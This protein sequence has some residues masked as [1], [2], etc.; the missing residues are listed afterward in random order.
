MWWNPKPDATLECLSTNDQLIQSNVLP[1]INETILTYFIKR[2]GTMFKWFSLTTL[3]QLQH[4][5]RLVV[6]SQ[7]FYLNYYWL[8]SGI[9]MLWCI[10]NNF[11]V[12]SMLWK[13]LWCYN[14][15]IAKGC[16]MA[17][18][19]WCCHRQRWFEYG[20]LTHH[21]R[22]VLLSHENYYFLHF[23]WVYYFILY[24]LTVRIVNDNW[25]S[26]RRYA[27]LIKKNQTFNRETMI[28]RI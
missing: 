25:L 6:N 16:P 27:I 19:S 18:W 2:F 14:W 21:L 26:Y 11:S 12:R 10:Y 13:R 7:H 28:L 22:H 23:C 1:P 17:T 3:F 24:W 15:C 9:S 4:G 20:M 5:K 8:A